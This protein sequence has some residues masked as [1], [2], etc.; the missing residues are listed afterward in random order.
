ME[1]S[2]C[3]STRSILTKP[4]VHKSHDVDGLK[5][6][7]V[8]PLFVETGHVIEWLCEIVVLVNLS[9]TMEWSKATTQLVGAFVILEVA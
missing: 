3:F 2:L 6:V 8:Q 1:E 4:L 7:S 9:V 5:M